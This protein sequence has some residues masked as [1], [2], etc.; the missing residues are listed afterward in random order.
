MLSAVRSPL[1]IL[2]I[3]FE[4]CTLAVPP[5]N[6]S[7]LHWPTISRLCFAAG[8]TVILLGS[9]LSVGELGSAELSSL[10]GIVTKPFASTGPMVVK[11]SPAQDQYVGHAPPLPVC[12]NGR[13]IFVSGAALRKH[14]RHGDTPGVCPTFSS[15]AGKGKDREVKGANAGTTLAST[16]LDLVAT[17]VLAFLLFVLGFVLRRNAPRARD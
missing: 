15:V 9:L 16:G 1:R 10:A 17:I 12:H 11:G 2:C 4:T 13:V 7:S 6:L 14:L 3:R 5:P 8:L